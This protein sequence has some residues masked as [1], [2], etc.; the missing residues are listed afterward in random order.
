MLLD[1]DITGILVIP[2]N[3]R[4]FLFTA[5]CKNSASAECVSAANNVCRLLC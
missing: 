1:S 2:R 5:T 4:I 3:F